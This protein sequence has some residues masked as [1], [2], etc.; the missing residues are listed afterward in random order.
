MPKALYYLAVAFIIVAG[1]WSAL[2]I[3]GHVAIN[4]ESFKNDM[5]TR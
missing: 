5:K 4:S 2:T 1:A 3:V